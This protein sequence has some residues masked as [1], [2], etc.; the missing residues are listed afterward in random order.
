VSDFGL[1]RPEEACHDVGKLPIKW[2][3]PEAIK[4]H[5]IYNFLFTN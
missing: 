2:M 3:A 4:E 5:V 1:T